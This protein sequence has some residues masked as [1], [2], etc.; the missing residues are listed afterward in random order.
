M[1]HHL[2]L[3][4]AL[5]LATPAFAQ[6]AAPQ[7]DAP[8]EAETAAATD[9]APDAATQ[10]AAALT[11]PAAPQ[12][13]DPGPLVAFTDGQDIYQYLCRTCHQYDGA[14]AS[15]AGA[16]PALAGNENLEFPDYPV[17]LVV[18]GQKGMPPFGAMLSDE[19]V[20]A[21]VTYVQTNFGNQYTEHPTAE[22][23]AAVRPEDQQATAGGSGGN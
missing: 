9:A 5:A 12:L 7:A 16:Y 22:T 23:V 2:T 6:E 21:V 15:G 18:N 20:V 4:V 19:Q 10:A 3:L 8:A 14:G 1:K 11:D 13:D 17:M